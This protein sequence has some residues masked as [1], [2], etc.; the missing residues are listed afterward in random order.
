MRCRRLVTLMAL[1]ALMALSACGV[2][3]AQTPE[4][5]GTYEAEQ[6]SIRLEIQDLEAK[7][8]LAGA[9]AGTLETAAALV[10]GAACTLCPIL[11][12]IISALKVEMSL[13]KAQVSALNKLIKSQGAQIA[14]LKAEISSA[15]KVIAA[16]REQVAALNAVIADLR[17]E[18]DILRRR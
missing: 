8:Q 6:A 2:A 18:I 1:L 14:A 16:Q 11:Q 17:R 9:N 15:N 10:D 3:S 13:L 4:A 7:A 5:I 12:D